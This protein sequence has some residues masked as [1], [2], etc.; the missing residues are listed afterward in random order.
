M[1]QIKVR[2]LFV[3]WSFSLWPREKRQVDQDVGPIKIH[4][5]VSGTSKKISLHPSHQRFGRRE[6]LLRI[7][8]LSLMIVVP[9]TR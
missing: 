2:P 6:S 7:V 4:F 3:T 9:G 8:C 1:T 5:G